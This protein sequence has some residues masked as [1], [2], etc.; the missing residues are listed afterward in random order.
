MKIIHILLTRL[1]T[2]FSTEAKVYRQRI[3]AA[4]KPLATIRLCLNEEIEMY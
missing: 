4:V 3:P 1:R 2:E